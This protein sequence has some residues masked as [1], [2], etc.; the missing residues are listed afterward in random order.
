MF[1]DYLSVP[2]GYGFSEQAV[3]WRSD[4][5]RVKTRSVHMCNV[6]RMSRDKFAQLELD[7][8]SVTRE[9]LLLDQIK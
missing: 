8:D 7:Q 9:E 6:M 2:Y 4:N 1:P 3:R 5:F